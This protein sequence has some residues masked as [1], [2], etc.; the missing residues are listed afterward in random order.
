MEQ[1]SRRFRKRPTMTKVSESAAERASLNS[2]NCNN[3]Y[4]M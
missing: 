2:T 1:S 4:V 3:S